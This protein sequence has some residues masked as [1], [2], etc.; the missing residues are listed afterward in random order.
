[1]NNYIG[2][3]Q[4]FDDCINEKYDLKEQLEKELQEDFHKQMLKEQ[5]EQYY[6]DLK[7][8]LSPQFN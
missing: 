2:S 6:K 4:A 5:E 1:M 3:Q 8:D 7:H